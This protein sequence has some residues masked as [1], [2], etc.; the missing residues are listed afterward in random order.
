MH[1]EGL[2]DLTPEGSGG[3]SQVFRAT[4]TRYNRTVAAKVLNFRLES[5]TDRDRFEQE[6]RAM[7]QLS[8]HPHIV[9]LY[10]TTYTTEGYP[11]I[12]MEYFAG[13]TL[14]TNARRG[15]SVAELLD[16][17]V[18]IASA[19]HT[20]HQRGVTHRDV[21]PQNVL[22]SR[23]AEPALTDFGISAITQQKASVG[24]STGITLAYA[25]PEALD[26]RSSARTDIYSLGA[27]LYTVLAGQRP[28]DS[29]T[30][31]PTSELVRRILNEDPPPLHQ[32][33]VSKEIDRTIRRIGMARDPQDRPETAR[34]FGEALRA[35]QIS[36]GLEPT[37]WVEA[38][39]VTDLSL[40]T[41]VTDDESITVVRT[42][43]LNNDTKVDVAPDEPEESRWSGRRI[44]A[45]IAGAVALAAVTFIALWASGRGGDEEPIIETPPA[46]APTP[47]EFYRGP[48]FP[49]TDVTITRTNDGSVLVEWT[50]PNGDADIEFEIQRLDADDPLITT[51]ELSAELPN[52]GDSES[53]CITMRAIGERG[54]VSADI[55][56]NKCLGAVVGADP[57]V[58]AVPPECAPGACDFRLDASGFFPGGTVSI[59]VE[60]PDGVD[61]N[62]LFG[63]AYEA[64]ANVTETGDIQWRFSPGSAAPRGDYRVTVVDDQSGLASIT[65]LTLTDE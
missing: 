29:P 63:T 30:K 65:F 25:A 32:F 61:L 56:A 62:A 5:T 19:L 26:G 4:E 46:S 54:Q 23:F 53:P 16:A 51:R 37:P 52:I 33:G 6:C 9:P 34:D 14:S 24:K 27:T 49:P 55:P 47:D 1:I 31:Q 7:A 57:I 21:K 50:N 45:L 28:F 43:H 59:L 8:D 40:P 48:I 3:F 2:A 38:A 11:V 18:K 36:E 60:D 15:A 22:L 13:G 35:L 20:A 17:G 58:A 12:I 42:H 39:D 64:K 44:A 41:E 10:S